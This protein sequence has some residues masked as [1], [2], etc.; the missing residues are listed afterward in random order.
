MIPEI[1]RP[2]FH[3]ANV[4]CKYVTCQSVGPCENLHDPWCVHENPSV[5]SQF[6]DKL[7]QI[8]DK[9]TMLLTLRALSLVPFFVYP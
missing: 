6:V 2:R 9:L 3:E 5:L 4:A 7:Q 8:L 1:L